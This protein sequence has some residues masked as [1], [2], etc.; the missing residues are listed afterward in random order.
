[1][2]LALIGLREGS[3][4]LADLSNSTLVTELGLTAE[5][6]V[7]LR[8]LSDYVNGNLTS[9]EL[10]D[11]GLLTSLNLTDIQSQA[12]YL[13]LDLNEAPTLE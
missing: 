5:Q 3:V 8:T 4:S 11:S 1:M 12:F 7:Y 10:A 2:T 9:K 6:R 13:F